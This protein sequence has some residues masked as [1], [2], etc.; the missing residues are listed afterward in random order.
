MF[1]PRLLRLHLPAPGS[2]APV[3]R[4]I[5]VQLGWAAVALAA[6]AGGAIVLGALPVGPLARHMAAHILTMNIVAPVLALGL[7]AASPRVA[8]A[9]AATLVTATTAQ[10]ALLWATHAPPVWQAIG[11]TGPGLAL[12]HGVLTAAALWFWLAV[13]SDRSAF[14]WRALVALALTGKLFCLLGVLMVFAPRTLYGA[15]ADMSG[16]GAVSD[17]LADQQLAGLMMVVACPLSYVLAGVVI[18]AKGLRD[19][20]VSDAAA[21]VGEPTVAAR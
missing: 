16:L 4:R 2:S 20:A 10:L 14:R 3:A 8:S 12:L 6:L 13:L 11:H 21:R 5:P 1:R 9:T 19:I 17:A 7:V 18:A 15:H